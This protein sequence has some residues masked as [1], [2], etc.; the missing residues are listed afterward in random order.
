MS[1]FCKNCI[2]CKKNYRCYCDNSIETDYVTGRV[3]RRDVD[4]FLKRQRSP[5]C[6]DYI[7]KD[8]LIEKIKKLF[9]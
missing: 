6:K 4:C 5:I 1:N 9:K 7:E 8:S 3:L 2:Y